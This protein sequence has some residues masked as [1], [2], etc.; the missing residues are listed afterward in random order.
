MPPADALPQEI[1]ALARRQAVSLRDD[2][3]DSDVAR[4]V[5]SLGPAVGEPRRPRRPGCRSV[6]I[7]GS[8]PASWG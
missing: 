7:G 2:T 5:R 4:L 6:S 3:W 8:P 1:R